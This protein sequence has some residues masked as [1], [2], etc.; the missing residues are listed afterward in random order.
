MSEYKDAAYIADHIIAS[1]AMRP[2][3]VPGRMRVL[4]ATRVETQQ[5]AL[6]AHHEHTRLDPDP[7]WT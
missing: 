7:S 5:G 1:E 3:R 4:E 6:A 2:R